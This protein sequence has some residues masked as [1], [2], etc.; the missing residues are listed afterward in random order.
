M[1]VRVFLLTVSVLGLCAPLAA[2]VAPL[3]L[4]QPIEAS[5]PTVGQSH[6]YRLDLAS[7]AELVLMACNAACS[8]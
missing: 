5:I 7:L 8:F 2:Q 4:G 6:Y 1:K 3:Q